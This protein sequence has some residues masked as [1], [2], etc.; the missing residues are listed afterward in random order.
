MF[1][2]SHTTFAHHVFTPIVL[3][4][5]MAFVAMQA[6]MASPKHR[7]DGAIPIKSICD[8]Q[9]IQNNLSGSYV[10]SNDIDANDFT[11]NNGVKFNF[12]P[13]GDDANSFVGILDGRGFE[14]RNLTINSSAEYVGLFGEIYVG[15]KVTN[16]R[17]S[18]AS[19]S[20]TNSED[21][22]VGIVAGENWGTVTASSV[23]GLVTATGGVEEVHLGGLV[24]NNN[25]LISSSQANVTVSATDESL[26][27]VIAGGAIG[28]SCCYSYG[29][30]VSQL[31]ATGTVVAVGHRPCCCCPSVVGGLIGTS[32]SRLS[33]SYASV[34]VV[35]GSEAWVGG[36]LGNGSEEIDSSFS[37]G[38]VSGGK[39]SIVGGLIGKLGYGTVAE[40][41]SLGRVKVGAGGALG[42]LVAELDQSGIVANSYWDVESSGTNVS[43]GGVGLTTKQMT[44][45]TYNSDGTLTNFVGFDPTVW[46]PSVKKNKAYPYYPSLWARVPTCFPSAPCS[47]TRWRTRGIADKPPRSMCAIKSCRRSITKLATGCMVMIVAAAASPD[48]RI[49]CIV[50]LRC[51]ASTTRA[52]RVRVVAST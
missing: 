23:Q 39:K 14:V 25:A 49:L 40:S 38:R 1:A 43:A 22:F 20:A 36:L 52:Q 33:Q 9:A 17:V 26:G 24:G 3:G 16:L 19:I 35:G 8:L 45:G 12:V 15:G 44:V 4:F 46:M 30:T 51:P 10:L 28:L 50:R 31:S 6:A 7:P 34:S 18:N 41:Y 48:M 29:S 42:G 13:I 21:S 47:I 32:G 37:T 2:V 5:L 27:T 11:C